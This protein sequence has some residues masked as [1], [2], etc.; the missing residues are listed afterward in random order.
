MTDVGVGRKKRT[1]KDG[2]KGRSNR[3]IESLL[4]CYQSNRRQGAGGI[5]PGSDFRSTA[6]K[7]RGGGRA[8]EGGEGRRGGLPCPALALG[9]TAGRFGGRKEEGESSRVGVP[10]RAA[11]LR[12]A[13]FGLGLCDEV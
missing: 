13:W 12:L 11:P 10:G 2:L 6:T 8:T 7:R 9:S 3:E 5:R 1:H 4:L